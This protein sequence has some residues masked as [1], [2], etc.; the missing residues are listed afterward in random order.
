MNS[1]SEKGV[2]NLAFENE[3]EKPNNKEKYGFMF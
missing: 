2:D 3:K 1:S